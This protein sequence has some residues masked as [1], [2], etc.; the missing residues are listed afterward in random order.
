MGA[1]G[2]N[3]ERRYC[4]SSSYDP[5][6]DIETTTTEQEKEERENEKK[7]KKH[8]RTVWSSLVESTQS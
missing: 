6:A 1:E 8:S 3:P 4:L 2:R 5:A 7:K